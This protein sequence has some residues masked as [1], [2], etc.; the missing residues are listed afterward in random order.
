MYVLVLHTQVNIL[1]NKY[2]LACNDD[3][4]SQILRMEHFCLKVR[5]DELFVI[6]SGER[7]FHKNGSLTKK[8]YLYEFIQEGSTFKICTVH[9]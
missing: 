4:N 2:I 6:M 1:T 8:E 7:L 3:K 5:R 9:I